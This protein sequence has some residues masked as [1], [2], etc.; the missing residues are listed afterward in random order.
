M[1]AVLI[2]PHHHNKQQPVNLEIDGAVMLK[3][4]L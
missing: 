4:T 3:Q 1:A 2:G